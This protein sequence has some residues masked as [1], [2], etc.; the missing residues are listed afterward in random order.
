MVNTLTHADVT[1]AALFT[2]YDLLP[3]ERI[4]GS[5]RARRMVGAATTPLFM[6]C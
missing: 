2:P 3:L 4:V 5:E 6:F 1:C